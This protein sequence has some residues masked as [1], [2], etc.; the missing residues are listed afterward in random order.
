VDRQYGEHYHELFQRHWWWRARAVFV[1][2]TLR[3]HRPPA[4]FQR[5][6][7]VGC[8]DGLFFEELAVLGEGVEGVE[9]DGALVGER[10]RD[11]I[12]PFDPSFQPGHR[13]SLV[14]MLDVLEHLSDPVGA[15]R[16]ARE[17][18]EP[19][20]LVVVTLPALRALWTR[21]D[22]LNHHRT[23]HTRRTLREVASAAGVR[24]REER[25]FFHWM[26][27]A[28]LAVRAKEAVLRSEPSVP[29]VPAA[30]VNRALFGLSRLEQRT[31][32]RWPLPLGG[33]LL[34]VGAGE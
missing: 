17:L 19:A 1:L 13:F 8:G 12:G 23:R 10:Y 24:F 31:L 18:L 6:L 15:M 22:E 32:G 16:R 28:K 34:A 21:H 20:G 29:A 25:Y 33:S 4:G 30:W 27:P 5:I 2:E 11:R 26:V 14:P 9:V 3:R 7:D